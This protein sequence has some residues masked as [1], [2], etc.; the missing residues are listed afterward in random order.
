VP[1]PASA[2]AAPG[3]AGGRWAGGRL[4]EAAPRWAGGPSQRGAAAEERSAR[5][6]V[7]VRRARQPAGRSGGAPGEPHGPL[8]PSRLPTRLRRIALREDHGRDSAAAA[9]ERRRAPRP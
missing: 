3:G 4:G 2:L 9:A 5:R 7:V 8:V 6:A 1:V